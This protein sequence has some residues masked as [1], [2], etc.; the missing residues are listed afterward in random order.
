LLAFLAVPFMVRSLQWW[1]WYLLAPVAAYFV[2]VCLVP[3]LRH[4]MDWLQAGHC[5]GWVL[6]ATAAIVALSSTALLRYDSLVHPD[7]GAL[8]GQLPAWPPA[9][10]VVAGALFAVLNAS[11]EEMIFRG[12]L[13]TALA[14]QVGAGW[15]VLVQAA[16]FGV[17]H[18]SGYPP[19]NRGMA[20]AGIY[21]VMLGVLRQ[22]AGGLLA[23]W[24]A[25]VC[26]DAVIFWIVVRAS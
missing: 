6:A 16:A 24:I 5:R 14:A 1:P 7:L 3:P 4:S 15:A 26:A 20:L 19:G 13:Q 9:A 10:L 17:G 21:G 11:L 25:H 2:T 12:V 22:R 8:T 23:P 18:G